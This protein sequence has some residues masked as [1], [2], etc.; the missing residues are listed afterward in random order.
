MDATAEQSRQQGRLCAIPDHPEL[1]ECRRW[2][3][4]PRINAVYNA[5]RGGYMAPDIAADR[6]PTELTAFVRLDGHLLESHHAQTHVYRTTDNGIRWIPLT[7]KVH[8]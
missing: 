1:A 2:L 3:D 6:H 8:A 5:K 7:T 4:S